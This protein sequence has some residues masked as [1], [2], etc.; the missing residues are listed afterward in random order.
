MDFVKNNQS[1]KQKDNNKEKQNQVNN[2]TLLEKYI[3]H[4]WNQEIWLLK[5]G[6]NGFLNECLTKSEKEKDF[7]KKYIEN[8][9]DKYWVS[10]AEVKVSDEM[11]SKDADDPDLV[12]VDK[13]KSKRFVHVND[14]APRAIV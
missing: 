6:F 5:G 11:D 9:D 14:W 4:M 8:F 7:Y 13:S 1:N 3:Q 10:D 2:V 12:N